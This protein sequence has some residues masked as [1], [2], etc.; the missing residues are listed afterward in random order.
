MTVCVPKMND[1]T[2]R[3]REESFAVKTLDGAA[4]DVCEI[5]DY[6]YN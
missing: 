4:V 1:I 6:D 2:T 5:Q 3:I